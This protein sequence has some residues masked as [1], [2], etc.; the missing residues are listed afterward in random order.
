MD[1]FFG[2]PEKS[3][4]EELVKEVESVSKSP[5][6]SG[7]LN[8]TSG[9]LAV[10]DKNRQIIALNKEFI[11]SLG[12][13]DFTDIL[14]LRPGELLNCI[15]AEEKPNGCGTTKYCPTCGAGISIVTSLA[16][17]EPCERNCAL[18][19]NRDGRE[20]EL[21]F[22]VKSFP[23]KI[24]EETF[25]VLFLQD[26]TKQEYRASLERIFFH[27]INNLLSS[28]ST[29]SEMALKEFPSSITKNLFMA[30]NRLLREIQMQKYLVDQKNQ[31]GLE[32]MDVD[33]NDILNELEVVFKTHKTSKGK[34]LIVKPLKKSISVKTDSSIILRV[35]SNM[36]TNAFEASNEGETVTIKAE[37]NDDVVT[38]KVHN[39][40][41]IPEAVQLRIFQKNYSTKDQDGRGFGTFSMKLLGEKILGGL[42]SFE[43][44]PEDGTTF[45]LKLLK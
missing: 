35:L 12:I 21:A 2:S 11:K 4:A 33:I 9:L 16:T 20:V 6:T 28:V 17:N 42:V 25:V 15:H 18:M 34:N 22:S 31:L 24:D 13:K 3:S 8:A 45:S 29:M 38:F 36:L 39:S 32:K 37:Y 26:I 27:D 44:S 43:S 41:Y 10:L 30:C 7:I 19:T 5:I 23:V 1:T 40:S 14:G